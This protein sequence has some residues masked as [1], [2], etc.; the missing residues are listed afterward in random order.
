MSKFKEFTVQAPRPLPVI[1]LADVSGSMSVDGKIQA[2]NLAV[3]EMLAAFQDEADLR[4]EIH[5]AVITF[6]GA[7]AKLHLPLKPARVQTWSELGAGG[8][9]PLGASLNLTHALIEDREVIPS[10]AYRP[11][12]VLVSDGIPTD[13][14]RDPL[15]RLLASERGGKAF[16]MTLAIGADADRDMLRA[17]LDDP[18]G[19]VYEADDARKIREFF[20]LVTMSVSSRSRSANP[21]SAPPPSDEDWDL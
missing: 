14:W 4:A 1:V 21:N 6:G 16:R 17:F 11:T 9:T 8:R 20:Q 2:L 15:K 3:H 13:S 5:L 7:E 12:I 19:R 10:R 18:E